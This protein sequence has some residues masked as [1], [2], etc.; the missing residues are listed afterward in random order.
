MYI[1]QSSSGSK[2]GQSQS[3]IAKEIIKGSTRSVELVAK[4]VMIRGPVGTNQ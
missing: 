2:V 4:K 3:G 1:H